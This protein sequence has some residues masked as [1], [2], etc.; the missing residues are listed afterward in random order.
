M[1]LMK[2]GNQQITKTPKKINKN[3]SIKYLK[4]YNSLKS[5]RFWHLADLINVTLRHNA[6]SI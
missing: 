4:K 1:A 3:I 5:K 6:F 2:K